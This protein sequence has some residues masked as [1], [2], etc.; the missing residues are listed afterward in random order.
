MLDLARMLVVLL[1]VAAWYYIA[2]GW[3][4]PDLGTYMAWNAMKFA[5]TM[6]VG[7]AVDRMLMDAVRG[8][9]R[10]TTFQ[11]FALFVQG[12]SLLGTV[13]GPPVEAMLGMEGVLVLAAALLVATGAVYSAWFK[14]A[15]ARA[16]DTN[17]R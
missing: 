13:L 8:A 6:L 2:A 12:G 5:A 3:L 11:L 10:G 15:L 7:V 17:T 9:W 1:A 4:S 14:P 16:L